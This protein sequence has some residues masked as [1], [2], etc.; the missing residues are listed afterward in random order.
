MID[1]NPT[2]SHNIVVKYY[3]SPFPAMGTGNM[4]QTEYDVAVLIIYM[5]GKER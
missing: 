4:Y 3:F 5:Y 2:C 1:D